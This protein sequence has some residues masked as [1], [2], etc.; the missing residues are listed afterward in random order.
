MAI[1]DKQNEVRRRGLLS[2]CAR[3][4]A[5]CMAQRVREFFYV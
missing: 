4:S 2:R 5:Q 3:P 1:R